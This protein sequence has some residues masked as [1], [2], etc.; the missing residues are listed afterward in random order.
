MRNLILLTILIPGY[1]SLLRLSPQ[2]SDQAYVRAVLFFS[3]SCGHCHYVITE[4]LQPLVDQYDDQLI[5]IGVDISQ[6]DGHELFVKVLEYYNIERGGVPFLVI[7]DRYL[8]GS[9]DIPEQFPAL[10]EQYLAQGGVDWP[11]IPGL[12]EALPIAQ[13]A[14]EPTSLP[15]EADAPTSI[16]LNPES[17]S[18]AVAPALEQGF[19]TGET[20]TGL[21]ERLSRDYAGNILAIIVLAGMFFVG[22]WG[23]FFLIR[24]SGVSMP[25]SWSWLIP[26]LCAA[27]MVVAGYLAYVETAQVEAFCGPVGDC[28]TVQQSPYAR[29]FDVIPIGVL[30]VVGYVM[31]F[32]AWLLGRSTRR[33]VAAYG[34]LALLTF[35]SLGL[36]FSIYLTFLEPFVIGATCAWCLTSAIT[37]TLLFGLSL[38]PGKQAFGYLI[39]RE[40]D[41]LHRKAVHGTHTRFKKKTTHLSKN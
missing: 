11:V 22:V 28:N 26:V 25:A 40:D 37:M 19:M 17:T 34:S 41:H 15:T 7:G 14:P 8:V 5:I 2:Y 13:E 12:Q 6:S 38:A 39:N 23:V 1:F 36:L 27:G 31:I 24:P 32:L 35:T 30:G 16:T 4:V 18:E 21:K 3:P 9:V 10:I 20:N 33:Q 29:L